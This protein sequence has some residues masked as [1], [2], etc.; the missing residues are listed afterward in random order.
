MS[1][2]L[3]LVASSLMLVVF[4]LAPVA[5]FDTASSPPGVRPQAD[6]EKRTQKRS[7]ARTAPLN[8][9]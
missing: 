1:A 8:E 3:A 5:P 6:R 2:F 9:N 7:G 4:S